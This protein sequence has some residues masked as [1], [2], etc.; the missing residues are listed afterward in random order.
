[1]L[2]VQ[3]ADGLS[4]ANSYASTAE[5]MAFA[6]ERGVTL[7][8]DNI[9]SLLIKATDYI[10][11]KQYKGEPFNNTQSTKFPVKGVGVPLP[12][13]KATMQLAIIADTIDLSPVIAS[14]QVKSEKVD[15][16]SVEY[17]E[18]SNDGIPYFPMIDDL[19]KPYISGGLGINGV[20]F[21]VRRG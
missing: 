11:S 10:D 3:T 14:G 19:L 2:V 16:I 13:K 8:S 6:L 20:N 18:G 5:L 4:N 7:V 15:V 21:S 17:F 12:I 1:M 9:E